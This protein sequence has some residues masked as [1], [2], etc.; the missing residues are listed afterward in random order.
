MH[1]HFQITSLS[2]CLQPIGWVLYW[3]PVNLSSWTHS[4]SCLINS[5]LRYFH[6]S[7]TD[8]I[9]RVFKQIAILKNINPIKVKTL[10]YS[11]M[12]DL[13]E[14]EPDFDFPAHRVKRLPCPVEPLDL[15]GFTRSPQHPIAGK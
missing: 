4:I 1:L 5:H 11:G 15:D 2:S 3:F 10:T 9:L 13:T 7:C 14:W 6:A 12:Y 8:G